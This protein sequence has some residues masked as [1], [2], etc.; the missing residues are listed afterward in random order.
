MIVSVKKRTVM[1]VAFLAFIT[2][3]TISIGTVLA[4]PKLSKPKVQST[5]F[6]I[7]WVFDLRNADTG[8]QV[9]TE[10]GSIRI[11][12]KDAILVG[13]IEADSSSPI[14]ETV[15]TMLSGTW[16]WNTLGSSFKGKW[17]IT[18]DNGAFQGS[19][20]GSIAVIYISGKFVGHGIDDLK[21]QK[22][23]GSIKGTVNN[24][25]VALTL[26]GKLTDK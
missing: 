10:T 20:V 22:I 21:D 1:L 4:N 6:T 5:P 16:L 15:W 19:V 14:S 9:I 26:R 7:K 8:E 24:Y 2:L 13:T 17:T 18:T 11:R 12:K 23:M 3:F 25:I